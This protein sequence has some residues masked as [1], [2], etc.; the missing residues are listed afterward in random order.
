MPP[1]S[2]RVTDVT[3]TLGTAARAQL[4]MQL[5]DIETRYGSQIAILM[6]NSI[7]PEPIEDF[8]NRVGT[9]WKIGRKGVGDGVL[10]IVAL[11]DHKARIDV[12]RSLEG[13]I[14][15]AVAKRI[16]TESLAPAFKQN[17]YADGLAAALTQIDQ[18]LR[19]EAA[20][21]A[22]PPPSAQARHMSSLSGIQSE[23]GA[24][25]PL[26]FIGAAIGVVLKRLFGGTGAVVAGGATG[27]ASFFIGFSLL[28]AVPLGIFVMIAAL[29]FGGG[30]TLGGH[31]RA[32]QRRGEWGDVAVGSLLGSHSSS[33][34]W[35]SG[36]SSTDN[37]SSGGGGDFSGGGAS[38]EW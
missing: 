8:A 23:E 12:A 11:Q 36:S 21:G 13:A 4:E 37:F 7:K 26:L 38:G 14:P 19:T 35:A 29:I 34:S 22:L 33:G 2:S 28:W 30:R 27:A 6:V 25:L 20:S 10:I 15:D 9:T 16:V 24:L 18:R 31:R 5:K 1:L 3:L 32:K 17:N